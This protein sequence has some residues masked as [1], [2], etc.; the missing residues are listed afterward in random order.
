MAANS[1]SVLFK[2]VRMAMGWE[3]DFSL[4]DDV[5]W[6]SVLNL[7]LKQGVYAVA[8]DGYEFYLKNNPSAQSF[9]DIQGNE[10]LKEDAFYTIQD[11]ETI[12]SQHY[13]AL[14]ALSEILAKSDIRFLL[15]KGFSCAQYYPLPEHRCCGDIDIF[16]GYRYSECNEAL[17]SSGITTDQHYYRHSVAEI[18]DVNIENHRVLCDLRGPKKQTRALEAQLKN[19]A[20]KCIN[21]NPNAVV[22]GKEVDLCV[23][24]SANFNALF[25]PWHV[26]AH[27]E[28]ER[29]TLRQLLD[30]ALFLIHEG[31]YIDINIFREAKKK[32]T[33]GF[34][35]FADILTNLSLRYFNIPS[36]TIPQE[37]LEDA[38][39]FDNDLADKVL[40]YMFV[41]QPRERDDN[42]WKFRL[43]NIRRIYKDRWKYRQLYDMSMISFMYYKVIGVLFGVGEDD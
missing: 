28:F 9:L 20:I 17:N 27:F 6:K 21:N 16:P 36:E 30:W 22:W 2:L 43:N 4:P 24:P 34:S 32:Y 8:M 38:S 31:K 11:T 26:S 33:Y 19:E 39:S 1:R 7:A 41:G 40:D 10:A 42:V 3:T 23:F 5:N 13:I 15:L 29:V 37:I 14:T 18:Y 35:K 25:L 12:Y